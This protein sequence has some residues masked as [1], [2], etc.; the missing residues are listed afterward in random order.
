MWELQADPPEGHPGQHAYTFHD[1]Y[2]IDVSHL[3]FNFLCLLLLQVSISMKI[4][5]L[6]QTGGGGVK[7][8]RGDPTRIRFRYG[9][10]LMHESWVLIPSPNPWCKKTCCSEKYLRVFLFTYMYNLS[11]NFFGS[12]KIP[13]ENIIAVLSRHSIYNF[14]YFINIIFSEHY[15]TGAQDTSEP[16]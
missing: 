6:D 15:Y 13:P 8:L 12:K 11:K 16:G 10:M 3:S 1:S 4:K 7:L 9:D 2:P 14:C 5:V